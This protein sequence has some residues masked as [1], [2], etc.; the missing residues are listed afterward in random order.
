MTKLHTALHEAPFAEFIKAERVITVSKD[1]YTKLHYAACSSAMFDE[2]WGR[3]ISLDILKRSHI[4]RTVTVRVS[5]ELS[6][7]A[8]AGFSANLDR[9]AR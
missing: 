5:T 2:G 1:A 9:M 3:G 7:A 6:P 4:K 8:H